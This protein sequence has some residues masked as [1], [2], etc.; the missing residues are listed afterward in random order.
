M[1]CSSHIKG[2]SKWH[3]NYPIAKGKRQSPID[4]V[5]HEALHDPS[6]GPIVVDYDRCT[7]LNISNSGHSVVVEFEDSDDRSGEKNMALICIYLSVKQWLLQFAESLN[8]QTNKQTNQS[9]LLYFLY[10]Y[11]GNTPRCD[12]KQTNN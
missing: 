5:P 11:R 9:V 12:E 6:L 3:R 4:I 8:K 7:S 2:P 10:M 1:K